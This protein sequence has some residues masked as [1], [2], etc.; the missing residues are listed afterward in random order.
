MTNEI[1]VIGLENVLLDVTAR[2]GSTIKKTRTAVNLAGNQMKTDVQARAPYKTGT[3]RRSIHAEPMGT[4]ERPEVR[5]GT[6]L[7]HA[8]QKEFGGFIYAKNAPYLVFK[9]YDGDWVSVKRVYQPP[10]PHFRPVFDLNGP[11]YLEMIREYLE[12][13]QDYMPEWESAMS[14]FRTVTGG[15]MFDSFGGVL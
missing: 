10:Q 5:V 3:Y 7:I 2:I 14:V 13:D 9:T 15:T 11:K 4:N 12:D 6:N 8:A 1:A